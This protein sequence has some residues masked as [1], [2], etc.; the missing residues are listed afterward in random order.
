VAADVFVSGGEPLSVTLSSKA[1]E[2]PTVSLPAEMVHFSWVPPPAPLPLADAPHWAALTYPPAPFT[3]TNHCQEYGDVPVT[4]V[5][6][7][8]VSG[9]LTSSF[10]ALSV[11]VPGAVSAEFTVTWSAGESAMLESLS[12]TT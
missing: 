12:V 5:V 1:Y 11:G 7:V 10:A 4:G 6:P 9:W 3:S 2:S 8:T